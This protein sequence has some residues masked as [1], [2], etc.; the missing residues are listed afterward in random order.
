MGKGKWELGF[1]EACTVVCTAI[2]GSSGLQVVQGLRWAA[3]PSSSPGH[4]QAEGQVPFVCD[5]SWVC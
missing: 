1:G 3:T 2:I 5:I 4:K